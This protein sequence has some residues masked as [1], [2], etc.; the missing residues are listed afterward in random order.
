MIKRR[1]PARAIIEDIRTGMGSA[2]LME[3]YQISP[4][5]LQTLLRK[6]INARALREADL[7]TRILDAPTATE[8]GRGRAVPRNYMFFTIPIFDV[9]DLYVEGIVNDISEKGLQ[10]EGVETFVGD[11]RTF[12]IR[13]D[14]FADVFPFAFEAICRWIGNDGDSGAPLAGFE[15]TNISEGGVSE[16][17]KLVQL[18]GL[19]E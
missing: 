4:V 16:I 6:L 1:I 19:G 5:G 17:Q 3:K 12:L 10:V 13:A 2:K 14:E 11:A 7:G 9:D 15:I 18:L 8:S